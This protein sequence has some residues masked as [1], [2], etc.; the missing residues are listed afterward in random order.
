M[1]ESPHSIGSDWPLASIPDTQVRPLSVDGTTYRISIALPGGPTP[2][3]G[4]PVLYLLDADAGFATVVETHRRLSR[5]PDATGVA[6]AVIVGI[7]HGGG[8]LYDPGRRERDYVPRALQSSH[9]DGAEAFLNFIETR[10]KPDIGA[11]LA[12]DPRRQALIGHSL[13]GYFTLWTLVRHPGAFQSY[14]AISP[15]LWRDEGLM[16]DIPAIRGD[17]SSVF[18][19]AGEWE[20]ALAPWQAEHANSADIARRRAERRMVSNARTFAARLGDHIGAGR[21]RFEMF[22]DQDHASVFGVAIN[23]ALRMVSGPHLT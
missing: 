6:P 10:L 8:G 17:I 18:I 20:E 16:A 13:S 7:G 21:V 12:V 1:T 2:A 14:A 11:T 19:A 5:R 22:P 4:F 23:R 9:T 3:G 15:S